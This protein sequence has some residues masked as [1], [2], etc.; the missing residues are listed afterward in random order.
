MR[1]PDAALTRRVVLGSAGA[2][3]GGLAVRPAAAERHRRDVVLLVGRVSLGAPGFRF[4]NFRSAYP[5]WSPGWADVLAGRPVGRGAALPEQD[6]LATA[7]AAAGLDPVLV[8]ADAPF[9]FSGPAP[10][11]V[12]R[13][14]PLGVAGPLVVASAGPG[15]SDVPMN[16]LDITPTVCGLAGVSPSPAFVGRDYAALVTRPRAVA[17]VDRGEG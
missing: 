15:S 3:V 12:I 11:L 13:L 7:L 5:F 9:A 1:P 2:L 14:P 16:P 8:A 4:T 10:A 17:A 6:T